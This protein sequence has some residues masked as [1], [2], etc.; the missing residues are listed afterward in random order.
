VSK[1]LYRI[2]NAQLLFDQ[3]GVII[4]KFDRY[5]LT[6][7]T[8]LIVFKFIQIRQSDKFICHPVNNIS[9]EK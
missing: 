5:S 4:V 1:L 3:N 8:I 7:D 9:L 6:S 2:I